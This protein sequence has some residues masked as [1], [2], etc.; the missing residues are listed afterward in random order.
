MGWVEHTASARCL[1]ADV[2]DAVWESL[3]QRNDF[4]QRFAESVV[5]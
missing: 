1:Q 2:F 3:R 5:M 4:T